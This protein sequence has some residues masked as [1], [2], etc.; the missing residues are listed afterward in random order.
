M[1][2]ALAETIAVLLLA[3]TLAFAVVDARTGHG[4]RAGSQVHVMEDP[5]ASQ[6]R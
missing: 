2:R 3:V 4:A 5:T 6:Y 1:P